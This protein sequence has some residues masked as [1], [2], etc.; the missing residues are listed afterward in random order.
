[1]TISQPS[2]CAPHRQLLDGGG[3]ERVAG[4]EHD[5]LA[6]FAVSKLAS[7]AIDVVLP[8]PLTPT[9]RITVG[10]SAANFRGDKRL[11]G[12]PGRRRRF[13]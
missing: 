7:L 10:F 8:T 3:A 5:R 12:I 11:I 4:G 6:G 13:P 2:R 1:M 9:T